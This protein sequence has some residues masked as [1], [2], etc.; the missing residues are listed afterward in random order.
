M[1]VEN[2]AQC[3]RQALIKPQFPFLSSFSLASSLI[4]FFGFVSLLSNFRQGFL[5]SSMTDI[6]SQVDLCCGR[7]SCA[8]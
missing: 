6:W 1:Y 4:I 7:L 8:L 3:L 2:L 5:N